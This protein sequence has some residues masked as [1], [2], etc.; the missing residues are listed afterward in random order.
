MLLDGDE[1]QV[2]G[3]GAAFILDGHR[4]LGNRDDGCVAE[5]NRVADARPDKVVHPELQFALAK[6]GRAYDDTFL[7][8]RHE[9]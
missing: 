5:H 7:Q 4:G 3:V 2:D 9:R 1:R 6:A 8:E